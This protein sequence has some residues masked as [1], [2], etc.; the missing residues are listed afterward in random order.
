M[1]FDASI[2]AR[3]GS[4]KKYFVNDDLAQD[5]NLRAIPGMINRLMSQACLTILWTILPPLPA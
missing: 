4:C 1:R 2:N 3:D 5:Y